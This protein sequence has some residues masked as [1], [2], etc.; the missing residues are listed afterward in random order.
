MTGAPWNLS[1]IYRHPIKSL[2][3]EA[4]DS[5]ALEAGR[6]VPHDRSWAIAHGGAWDPANP[7]WLGGSASMVSTNYVPRL[8]QVSSRYDAATGSVHLSHPDLGD[9]SV[10]PSDPL[11]HPVLT[12]WLE[13][14]LEGTGRKGPFHVCEAPGV[15]FTDFE[16]THISIATQNSLRALEQHVGQSLEHIR[17]RM[18]LWLEGP[19]PWSE[20]DW[21][22]REIEIGA[23][24]LKVI[25][26]DGRCN[27]T[28]ANPTTGKRDTQIPALLRKTF[29]H[30]DFGVYAQVTQ[31]GTIR[32]GDTARL[33]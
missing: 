25:D 11:H 26:R 8:A 33:V 23:V 15:A 14:L 5:V 9:L 10:Q 24:R 6:P 30:M 27:A 16:E 31:G 32:T 1:A 3:E 2:G 19:A 13:P 22:G 17:F 29:G 20:L 4:L 28:N 12:N 21:V 18:N 7:S